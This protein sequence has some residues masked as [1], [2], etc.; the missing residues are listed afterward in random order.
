MI[1][2]VQALA[3]RIASIEDRINKLI[4]AKVLVWESVVARQLWTPL[5]PAAG[6]LH[7][8]PFMLLYEGLMVLGVI[9][10]TLAIYGWAWRLPT[11]GPYVKI[12]LSICVLYSVG[13]ALVVMYVWRGINRRLRIEVR[14]LIDSA[15]ADTESARNG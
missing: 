15:S 7:P 1:L 9:G 8:I 14:R 5:S 4:D 13:S 10:F 11:S 6:I 12:S 2:A 3:E